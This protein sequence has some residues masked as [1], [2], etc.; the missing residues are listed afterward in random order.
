MEYNKNFIFY[1]MQ[2]ELEALT[3]NF[4]FGTK[5][6]FCFSGEEKGFQLISTI[7]NMIPDVRESLQKEYQLGKSPK[8][9]D[10]L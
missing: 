3:K 6:H 7:S 5:F 1:P 4:N 9:N 10:I 2:K 8:S